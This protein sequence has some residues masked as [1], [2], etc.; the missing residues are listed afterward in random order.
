MLVLHDESGS[1]Y[2]LTEATDKTCTFAQPT[3]AVTR[4]LTKTA[5]PSR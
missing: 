1:N 3:P 4:C 5:T 2:S